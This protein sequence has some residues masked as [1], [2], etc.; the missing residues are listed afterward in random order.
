MGKPIRSNYEMYPHQTVYLQPLNEKSY[1][2]QGLQEAEI[3]LVGQK[4]ITVQFGGWKY[5]F[6]LET[7]EQVVDKEKRGG[8]NKKQRVL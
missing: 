7:L 4:F 8:K 2:Y 5:K 3:I 1:L 6:D